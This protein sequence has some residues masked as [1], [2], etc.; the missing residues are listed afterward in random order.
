MQ[1][2]KLQ[3]EITPRSKI[4]RINVTI[5]TTT[6]T[7]AHPKVGVKTIWVTLWNE[8]GSEKLVRGS[9]DVTPSLEMVI[10]GQLTNIE[11]KGENL[12]IEVRK[13]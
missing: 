3:Y 4:P 13:V 7:T 12:T 1:F 5:V 2:V 9:F 10:R 11:K 8:I 6:T